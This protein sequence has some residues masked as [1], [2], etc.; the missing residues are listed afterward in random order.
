M[1]EAEYQEYYNGGDLEPIGSIRKKVNKMAT[2]KKVLNFQRPH[3]IIG[4]WIDN[5]SGNYSQ[6]G[7]FMH[8]ECRD[9]WDN[10]NDALT[11]AEELTRKEKDNINKKRFFVAQIY[12]IVTIENPVPPIR[13]TE[14]PRD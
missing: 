6:A 13:V 9:S 11:V 10:Y 14:L 7:F 2:V 12:S 3:Y 5:S 8:G 1:T 4:F